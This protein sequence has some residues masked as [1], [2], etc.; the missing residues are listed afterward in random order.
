MNK[1]PHAFVVVA[2]L[3]VGC[4]A[5]SSATAEK[6]E[7]R[8][9]DELRASGNE[10]YSRM[11]DA[12]E[13]ILRQHNKVVRIYFQSE[14]EF[15][16]DPFWGCRFPRIRLA[17]ASEDKSVIAAVRSIFRRAHDVVV[18]EER[19]GVISIIIGAPSGAILKTKFPVL[20]FTPEEQYN[21]PLALGAIRAADILQKAEFQIKRGGTPLPCMCLVTQPNDRSPHLPSTVTDM[22]LDEI[23]DLVALTFRTDISYGE[24]ELPGQYTVGQNTRAPFMFSSTRRTETPLPLGDQYAP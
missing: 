24:C 23:L 8:N 21:A 1:T 14:S 6:S 2:A 13:P 22:T 9:G 12:L 5:S 16:H 7:I 18:A 10:T 4:L 20:N 3:M 15:E 11:I 17:P 19:Q